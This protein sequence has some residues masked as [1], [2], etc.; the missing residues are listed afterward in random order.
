MEVRKRGL[1]RLFLSGLKAPH[2]SPCPTRVKYM[3]LTQFLLRRF[4][5]CYF[6]WEAERFHLACQATICPITI[7][8]RDSQ[9]YLHAW[10]CHIG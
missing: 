10:T 9:S 3:C 1:L 4:K 6:Y 5:L 7:I 8:T 2:S